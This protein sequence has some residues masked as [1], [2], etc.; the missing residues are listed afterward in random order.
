[1]SLYRSYLHTQLFH[2]RNDH[3]VSNSKI[4]LKL[5]SDSGSVNGRYFSTWL[6]DSAIPFPTNACL[7]YYVPYFYFLVLFNVVIWLFCFNGSDPLSYMPA[8]HSCLSRTEMQW[9]VEWSSTN[10]WVFFEYFISVFD[11]TQWY[12]VPVPAFLWHLILDVQFSLW[13]LTITLMYH[14]YFQ[15]SYLQL[16]FCTLI[17]VKEP[18]CFRLLQRILQCVLGCVVVLSLADPHCELRTHLTSHVVA[19]LSLGY[20]FH[21]EAFDKFSKELKFSRK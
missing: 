9:H 2:H 17:D 4:S 1:M 8:S 7:L 5:N 19:R 18:L 20:S 15:M 6:P 14:H 12:F 3:N 16:T 10:A 11:Y 13:Y 21:W